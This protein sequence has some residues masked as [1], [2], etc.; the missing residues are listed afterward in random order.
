MRIF[1]LILLAFIVVVSCKKKD[2]VNPPEAALLVFPNKNSECTIGNDVSATTREV[3][4]KWQKADNT[5][6][7]ELRVTNIDANSTQTI[8]TG[9]LSARLPLLK[10]AS[11]SWVVLSSNL[12][13]T[14]K[15]S[16]ATW[17]FYNAGTE[18]SRPPFAAEILSPEIGESLFKDINN[19]VTLSWTGSDLDNDIIEYDIYFDT[20]TPPIA[21]L[22]TVDANVS[23]QKVTVDANTVYYW[24]IVTKDSDGHSSDSGISDFRIY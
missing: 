19:E 3:D 6:S 13:V 23:E 20:V 17:Q 5:D 12:Q 9:A 11:F 15:V 22:T 8:S 4:F 14:Q 18:T 2:P 16:S 21:V 7:Y 24:K 1:K 10:G